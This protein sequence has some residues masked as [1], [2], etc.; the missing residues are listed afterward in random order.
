MYVIFLKQFD[1][2]SGFVYT[3]SGDVLTGKGVVKEGSILEWFLKLS[4]PGNR[5]FCANVGAIE[6]EAAGVDLSQKPTLWI[7]IMDELPR[8][9]PQGEEGAFK[10]PHHTEQ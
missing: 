3:R 1:Q 5:A 6:V 4:G 9:V 8:L 2:L 10:C 7:R